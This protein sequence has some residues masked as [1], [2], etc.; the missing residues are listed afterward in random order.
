MQCY[1]GYTRLDQFT[2]R[3]ELATKQGITEL[4]GKIV[5]IVYT[6]GCTGLY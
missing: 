6:R 3:C 2:L 4:H 1:S 5:K